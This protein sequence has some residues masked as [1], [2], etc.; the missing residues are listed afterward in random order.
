ALAAAGVPAA[1]A[2]A[3]RMAA[4]VRDSVGLQAAARQ[5][6]LA[7]RVLLRRAGLPP[8]G[9]PVVLVDDVVTT[10]ATAVACVAALLRAGVDTPAIV[11]LA[12]AGCHAPSHPQGGKY[13][14]QC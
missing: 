3:L 7:G 4:G 5:A 6:N 12:A 13:H 14:S 1:V 11:A 10:G 2:P 8:T 9:T